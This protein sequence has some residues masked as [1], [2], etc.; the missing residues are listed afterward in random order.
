MGPSVTIVD[1]QVF[2]NEYDLFLRPSSAM[3]QPIFAE[4]AAR[5][6]ALD[7]WR[8]G[9]FEGEIPLIQLMPQRPGLD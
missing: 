5:P 7:R 1:V 8:A 6:R 4:L 3:L 9:F 2:I